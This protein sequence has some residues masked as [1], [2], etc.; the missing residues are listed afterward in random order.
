MKELI[1]K[2]QAAIAAQM[3]EI[4]NKVNTAI[5][6][7]PPLEQ[8]ASAEEANFALR[9]M[10]AVGSD[11][12]SYLASCD[13]MLT[14]VL[15][16]FEPQLAQLM[17]AAKTETV[18][19]QLAA[20]EIIRKADHEAAVQTA[21]TAA[22]EQERTAVA[23][24]AEA[25]RVVSENRGKL[26]SEHGIAAEVAQAV[27]A[28]ALSATAFEQT[29]ATLKERG[30]ALTGIGIKDGGVQASLLLSGG[31][32]ATAEAFDASLEIQKKVIS[33]VTAGGSRTAPFTPQEQSAEGT[34]KPAL[35]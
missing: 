5:A 9:Q 22:V 30:A 18:A 15:S 33:Q 32:P 14:E 4:K 25:A 3:A 26:T 17:D 20:G 19:A 12:C 1:A 29:A 16:G 34:A 21:A 27:S 13:N 7:L 28:E 35:F 24:A 2:I 6:G 8:Q 11:M 31:M 10:K 23:Q